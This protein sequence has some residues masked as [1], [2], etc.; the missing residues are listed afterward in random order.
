MGRHR[1]PDLRRGIAVFHC[2]FTAL[3]PLPFT[4]VLLLLLVSLDCRRRCG[5][6]RTTDL[7]RPPGHRCLAVLSLSFRSGLSLWPMPL[8][9]FSMSL[10]VFSQSSHFLLL[11]ACRSS[12]TRPSGGASLGRVVPLRS[13]ATA[14]QRADPPGSEAG[15]WCTTR[16]RQCAR[17]G[18]PGFAPCSAR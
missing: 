12:P 4:A 13:V 18:W 5:A 10:T 15:R 14:I 1:H 9:V 11:I 17:R 2:P 3:S 16:S 6:A 8:T 7:S